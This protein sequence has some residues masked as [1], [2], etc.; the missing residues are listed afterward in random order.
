MNQFTIKHIHAEVGNFN[1][2]LYFTIDNKLMTVEVGTPMFNDFNEWRISGISIADQD[3]DPS[4]NTVELVPFDIADIYINA[5]ELTYLK[6]FF[7]EVEANIDEYLNHNPNAFEPFLN[8]DSFAA[9]LYKEG[10]KHTINDYKTVVV[11][12]Y[13]ELQSIGYKE[14]LETEWVKK[15]NLMV[16]DGIYNLLIPIMEGYV[17]SYLSRLN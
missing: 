2:F 15:D 3:Y 5:E 11:E 4:Q 13:K 9:I 12:D 10:L 7:S 8:Y 17:K 16:K 14:V 1:G 6:T